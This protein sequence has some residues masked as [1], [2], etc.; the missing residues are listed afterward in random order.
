MNVSG[1]VWVVGRPASGKTTLARR[2]TDAMKAAELP[3]LWLDSDDLRAVM[4]PT[5]T[6]R[7][8]ERDT[9]YA[10]LAKLVELCVAG[11]VNAVVSATASKREYR[12]VVRQ[13]VGS[14]VEVYV[15][16]SEE[17]L[18]ERDPKGLY[19]KVT[20]G[21]I[22]NLPGIDTPFDEPQRADVVVDSDTMDEDETFRVVADALHARLGWPI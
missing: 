13:R 5:A 11:G 16:C 19:A 7:E 9:F 22:E 17:T 10:T 14:F 8:G 3:V 20:K 21:V 18:R 12:R 1:V 4:T 6:Y 15:R 2:L